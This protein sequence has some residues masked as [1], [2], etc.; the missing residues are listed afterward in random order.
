MGKLSLLVTDVNRVALGI[1]SIS[2]ALT[3]FFHCLICA[4]TVIK[5]E[6]SNIA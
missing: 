6:S 1:R 3:T 5:Y 2:L 4:V